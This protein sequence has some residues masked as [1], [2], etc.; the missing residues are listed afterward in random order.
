M[1]KLIKKIQ[2]YT[3]ALHNHLFC[4]VYGEA[5]YALD[6]FRL[7]LTPW[8]FDLFDWS[9]LRSQATVFLK[10]TFKERRAD[11]IF[12]VQMKNSNVIANIIFLF[13]HKSYNDPL[14]FLQLLEYQ[15]DIYIQS[16]R[17]QMPC[18]VIPV[19]VYAGKASWRYPLSFHEYLRLSHPDLKRAF[20]ENGLCCVS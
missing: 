1:S 10:E 3:T 12:S 13:E 7:I 4:E 14:F 8:E 6:L 9:T 20:G 2:D 18:I 19:L 16:Q 17:K 5:K 15:L 11:L